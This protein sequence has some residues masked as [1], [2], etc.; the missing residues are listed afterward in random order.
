MGELITELLLRGAKLLLAAI[1]AV[2]LYM[3]ANAVDPAAAGAPL[4]LA[5]YAA[6]AA[7]LLLLESS[8]L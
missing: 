6:A 7:S 8:P 4:A 3:V 5:A 2:P 1:L